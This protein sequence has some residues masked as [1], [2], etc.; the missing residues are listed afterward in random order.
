MASMRGAAEDTYK[1]KLDRM[2]LG[3]STASTGAK[4]KGQ[5]YPQDDGTQGRAQG[6]R[7]E[8]Y[9]TEADN[10]R[11]LEEKAPKALRLD[12]KPFARGGKVK[13]CSTTVN[14]IVAPQQKDQDAPPMLPPGG[15]MPMPPPGAGA[16]GP[17]MPPPGAGGPPMMRARGGKVPMTAG[18]LSGE[19]RL[20]KIKIYGDRAKP[21]AA[22]RAGRM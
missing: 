15:P 19:G 20:E 3:I 6:G 22:G 1:G 12:R 2:G 8:G 14:V 11:T 16:G 17:P 21:S 9:E 13:K 10:E 7:A 4:A 5:V 18:A